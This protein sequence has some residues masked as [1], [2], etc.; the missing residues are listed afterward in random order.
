[1]GVFCADQT[2]VRN[3]HSFS[4]SVE[5]KARMSVGVSVCSL[6]F[7]F[8]NIFELKTVEL[9][10]C[11]M[12]VALVICN[13]VCWMTERFIAAVAEAL[14][15]ILFPFFTSEMMFMQLLMSNR[16]LNLHAS[17]NCSI[18]SIVVYLPARMI[19]LFV[20]AAKREEYMA[21]VWYWE[22]VIWTSCLD[23][24]CLVFHQV[25]LGIVSTECFWACLLQI[26]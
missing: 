6:Q 25:L 1:M 5:S 21:L 19:S 23:M 17:K 7:W 10:L 4:R 13:F 15:V 24:L 3:N 2:A 20:V 14:L 18:C 16:C 9:D 12:L 22:G 8:W 11:K 26:S